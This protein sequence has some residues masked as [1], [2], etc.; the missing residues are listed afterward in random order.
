MQHL[1]NGLLFGLLILVSLGTDARPDEDAAEAGFVL[2]FNGQDLSGWKLKRGGE[3]LEGKA[4][5]AGGRFKVA[6]RQLILDPTVKGDVVIETTV[7]L[8]GNLRLKFEFLP[9]AGCNNDLFLRGMKF[10]LKAGDVKNLK[11]DEWNQFEIVIAGSQCRP[12][13]T[14]KASR[15]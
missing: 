4:E 10:D 11:Q 15:K 14:A 8:A 6:E 9:G 12:N 2:L 13:A 1:R 7:E 3:T 5:A